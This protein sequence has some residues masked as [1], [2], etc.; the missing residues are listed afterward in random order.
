VHLPTFRLYY[1]RSR[2]LR[3]SICVHTRATRYD[4]LCVTFAHSCSVTERHRA[5]LCRNG[6]ASE[7]PCA[8]QAR[9]R[10]PRT[11]RYSL[12]LPLSLSLSLS[13]L[14]T[15][16]LSF[17][18][19]LR[20]SLYVSLVTRRPVGNRELLVASALRRP[21][22]SPTCNTDRPS[23]SFSLCFC[24]CLPSLFYLRQIGK[25]SCFIPSTIGSSFGR[26]RYLVSQRAR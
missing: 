13:F 4:R 10:T 11:M 6:C 24:L 26:S 3:T 15:S 9:A 14:V 25:R 5:A 16:S 2:P 1:A 22:S 23:I 7:T 18:H 20:N 21:S 8:T 17:V 12:F 19:V